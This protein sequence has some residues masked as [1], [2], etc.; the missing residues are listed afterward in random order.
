MMRVAWLLFALLCATSAQAHK[1]SDSYL[2]VSVEQNIVRGQ[3]DIALRDLDFAI[4]LD[5][6]GNGEITWGELRARQHDGIEIFEHS[7]GPQRRQR[8]NRPM[9]TV[10]SRAVSLS[11]R[12]GKA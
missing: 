3:W 8:M 12:M 11:L 10:G 6:N 9:M 7:T 1:P 4:G 2:V 5:S